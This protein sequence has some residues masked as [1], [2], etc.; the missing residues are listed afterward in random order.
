M[1]RFLWST[2]SFLGSSANLAGPSA[3][4]GTLRFTNATRQFKAATTIASEGKV[5]FAR[6]VT[7][8]KVCLDKP[9][10]TLIG[11][12]FAAVPRRKRLDGFWEA[13]NFTWYGALTSLAF[14]IAGGLIVMMTSSVGV[15]VEFILLATVLLSLISLFAARWVAQIVEKVPN[16]HTVGGAVFAIY[17]NCYRIYL[18]RRHWPNCLH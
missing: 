15:K 5:F 16:T 2:N 4:S 9:L 6:G 12:F 17:R 18:W 14:L 1:A 7:R 3:H 11:Q 10:A 8:Q 13:R